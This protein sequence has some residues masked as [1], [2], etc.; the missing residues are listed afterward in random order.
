MPR[1]VPERGDYP[2]DISGTGTGFSELD[3]GGFDDRD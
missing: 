3:A 2:L 1:I